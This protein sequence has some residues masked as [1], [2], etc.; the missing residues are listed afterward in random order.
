MALTRF[1]YLH[2]LRNKKY[3]ERKKKSE[4]IHEE[5]LY[6]LSFC[7]ILVKSIINFRINNY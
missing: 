5:L 3:K 2:F 6:F 4:N 7:G 1:G